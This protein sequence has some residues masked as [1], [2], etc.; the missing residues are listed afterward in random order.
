MLWRFLRAR[1]QSTCVESVSLY[2]RLTSFGFYINHSRPVKYVSAHWSLLR[3]RYAPL[4]SSRNPIWK[5]Y[6]FPS[7]LPT[8]A[9]S[10][11][12]HVSLRVPTS[13]SSEVFHCLLCL[14]VCLVVSASLRVHIAP[15]VME[16]R[17]L[18]LKA[19]KR[20]A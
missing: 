8:L 18:Q 5:R 13:A 10:V 9:R 17:P 3:P 1:L 11:G 4:V 7:F 15:K 14:A 19:V 20:D 2:T 6:H 16:L 12:Q